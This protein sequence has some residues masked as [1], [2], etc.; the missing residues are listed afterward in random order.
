MRSCQ[1]NQKID[2]FS[3]VT[4]HISH[5]NSNYSKIHFSLLDLF[6]D[7]TFAIKETFFTRPEHRNPFSNLISK[8]FLWSE[9]IEQR[10]LLYFW[11]VREFYDSLLM[12]KLF[13]NIFSFLQHMHSTSPRWEHISFL[14]LLINHPCGRGKND[15]TEREDFT[16]AH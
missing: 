3:L 4:Q 15:I 7:K 6:I 11:Y 14:L 2:D 1:L 16:I 5:V 10:F 8:S 9:S 13:P 12:K